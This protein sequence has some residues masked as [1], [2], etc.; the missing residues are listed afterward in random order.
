MW[1]IR[2]VVCE[3]NEIQRELYSAL[4]RDISEK[5]KIDIEIKEYESGSDLMLDLENP[6]FYSILDILFL[7]ISMPGISGIETAKAAR[8]VGY[9]G[10]IIFLTVSKEHY[11]EAF[12]VGAFNYIIKGEHDGKRFEEIFLKA[13]RL[14]EELRKEVIVLSGGYELRQIA[15]R[16]IEYF[17]VIKR[18][19]TV[20]YNDEKFKFTSS[21]LESLEGRL[22]DHGFQRI[23]RNYLVSLL[24]IKKLTY[25]EVTMRSGSVLPVGRKYYPDLKNAVEKIK[26]H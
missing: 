19:L 17:E 4:C 3:D 13:V 15:V 10:I 21:N 24:H 6:K 22:F 11:E 1:K 18:V 8:E 12:D 9:T 14:A 23:H 26:M 7:D 2:I 5:H 16:D 25:K 20:Y